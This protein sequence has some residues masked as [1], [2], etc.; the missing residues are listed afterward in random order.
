MRGGGGANDCFPFDYL[1]NCFHSLRCFVT[2][3]WTQHYIGNTGGPEVNIVSTFCG[4]FEVV[5]NV[6]T[7]FFFQSALLFAA[8]RSYLLGNNQI[9]L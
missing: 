7:Y 3:V 1:P 4:S 6:E 9:K 5:R 2:D 8:D